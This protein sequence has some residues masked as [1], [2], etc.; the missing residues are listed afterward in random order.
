MNILYIFTQWLLYCIH[1]KLILLSTQKLFDKIIINK[2]CMLMVNLFVAH[3]TDSS[4]HIASKMGF[5]SQ[6][7]L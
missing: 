7:V 2:I 1:Y 5:K 3:V 6:T 4:S